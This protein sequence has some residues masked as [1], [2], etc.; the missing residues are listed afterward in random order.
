M[1]IEW[2]ICGVVLFGCG[3]SAKLVRDTNE[4][5]VTREDCL[6]YFR[7]EKWNETLKC[8]DQ[9]PD[10]S[11]D[12][13][14]FDL[15]GTVLLRSDAPEK[16]SSAFRQAIDQ[17]IKQE[18]PYLY[19]KWGE[20]LWQSNQFLQGGKAMESYLGIIESPKPDIKKRA[21]YY[22]R[23]AVLA[24]SLYRV[25]RQFQPEPLP[26]SVNTSENELGI[27]MTYDRRSLILT[28]RSDQEDLFESHWRNGQWQQAKP[29]NALNTPDNE[30]AAALSG[31][32][33]LLVFTACQRPHGVGSCD[34]YFSRMNDTG[35]SK[36]E[37]LPVINSRYWDSQPALSP[38]GRVIIFSSERPG[39]YGGRDLWLSVLGKDGWIA[40]I[41]L[42][43]TINS[44]GNEEN[45]FLHSDEYTL[46][47]TSDYWPGFGGRDL[48]MA[49][50]L[51]GNQWSEPYNLGFPINSI[52]NEEGV[53]IESSGQKGYFSSARKG[54]FDLYSFEVDTTIQPRPALLY[55]M[56]VVDSLTGHP[57][58]DVSVKAYDW[59]S[60]RLARNSVT[61]PEGYAAFLISGNREYGITV[62]EEDYAFRSYK[63]ILDQ[64][65]DQDVTDTIRMAP[66]RNHNRIILENVQFETGEAQ[67]LEASDVELNELAEYL[68]TN[69][70]ITIAL[71]GHTDNVG[72]AADNLTLS[73]KRADAVKTYLIKHG[74]EGTR[75][76]ALGMGE[77]QPIA[78]N[79][80][81]EGRQRNR[82]TEITIKTK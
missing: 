11:R 55:E 31:D 46:Y 45:P 65:I 32:G 54:Q 34:L 81:P 28:R 58:Q 7:S 73:Q 70:D 66:I 61:D 3:P 15:K 78:P 21:D 35:W 64:G 53:F 67:L 77:T 6:E 51:S 43:P 16:A 18:N 62:S 37:L 13:S 10:S 27:S 17:D 82:R 42:G 29:M 80:T 20:S 75:I 33:N 59:T 36:P 52:K 60:Q 50:R 40:P 22:I 5:T 68:T 56:I 4:T 74:I 63:I 2:L 57:L 41:N 47:F 49:H 76:E 14:Y 24:D 26:G 19:F 1:K 12:Q 69:P 30:G 23:S 72:Q 71:T 8:L 9:I 48:F 25:P 79:D 44:P 39:G 38:D